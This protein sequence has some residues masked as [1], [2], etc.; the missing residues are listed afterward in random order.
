MLSMLK[1]NVEIWFHTLIQPHFA[2]ILAPICAFLW[3]LGGI[4]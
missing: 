1:N 4:W 2:T 3:A